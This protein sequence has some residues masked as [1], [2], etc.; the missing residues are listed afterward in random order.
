LAEVSIYMKDY[1]KRIVRK[2]RVFNQTMLAV[3]RCTFCKVWARSDLSTFVYLRRAS[4]FIEFDI[5]M[6]HDSGW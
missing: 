6:I 5:E 2:M 3:C 1:F 4:R